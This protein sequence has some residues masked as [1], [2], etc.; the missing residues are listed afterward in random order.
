MLEDRCD[1]FILAYDS[2]SFSAA[3]AKVPMSPQGFAKAIHNLERDLGVPLFVLGDDGVR[4]PTP[5]AEEFYEYARHVQ[6][7]RN[8]LA[9]AFECIAKS[10]YLEIRIASSLGVFGMLGPDFLDGFKREHPDASVTINELP[11]SL[12]ESLLR[13][14]LYDLA[15][16]ILPSPDDFAT[17]P[18]YSSPVEYWVHRDDPLSGRERLGLA[19]L[20]GRKVAI[21]GREYKCHHALLAACERAGV[22]PPELVECSEIFWIY[23]FAQRGECLGFC[24]PHLAR[25]DVFAGEKVRAVPLEGL[26]WA[27][28]ISHLKT[29][30]L[31]RREQD[32]VDYVAKRAGALRTASARG[33]V[34]R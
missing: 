19:D 27:F 17:V 5:Y 20:S 23:E 6:S 33:I 1:Y 21:P 22:E 15:L 10:G 32:F 4:R 31:S 25:L 18:L 14:G 26:A 34:A 30:S 16:T 11:D 28:G 3:A 8:L 7:E 12:C 24:L 29:R 2:P 13:D 9:G